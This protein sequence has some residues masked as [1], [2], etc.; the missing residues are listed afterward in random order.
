MTGEEKQ[1]QSSATP[2]TTSHHRMFQSITELSNFLPL[3]FQL[4]DVIVTALAG[5]AMCH[6]IQTEKNLPSLQATYSDH[7]IARL[8]IEQ[9]HECLTDIV[10]YPVG[11]A[12][13]QPPE[14]LLITN[15][16]FPL[17]AI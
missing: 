5:D 13:I 12:V 11:I 8:Y 7:C 14:E 17:V 3:V 16:S 15:S 4:R 9:R 2:L 10:Q 1:R 6:E